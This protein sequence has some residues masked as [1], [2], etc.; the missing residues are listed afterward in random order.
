MDVH[1]SPHG[2]NLPL[3]R[4]RHSL[5]HSCHGR[6]RRR[7]RVHAL[8]RWSWR[9]TDTFCSQLS[10][11][12]WILPPAHSPCKPLYSC[13]EGAPSRLQARTRALS[14]PLQTTDVLQQLC[15]VE[16]ILAPLCSKLVGLWQRATQACGRNESANLEQEKV[17]WQRMLTRSRVGGCPRAIISPRA[18]ACAR[19]VDSLPS[20][21]SSPP[22]VVPSPPS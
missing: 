12:V 9:S 10:A 8:S 21:A 14:H 3:C 22:C 7:S 19:F 17:H 6:R 1:S 5:E 2:V 16:T 18:H 13:L 11:A 20:Q 4:R 15:R